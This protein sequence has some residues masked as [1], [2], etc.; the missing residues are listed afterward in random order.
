[1]A[2]TSLCVEDRLADDRAAAHHEVE[3]ALGQA[4]AVQDVDERPG[5]SPARGRPA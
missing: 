2:S 1:M 4:G 3:H 5:R